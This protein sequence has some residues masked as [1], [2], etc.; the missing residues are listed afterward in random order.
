[1][2]TPLINEIDNSHAEIIKWDKNNIPPYCNS[3]IEVIFN[4]SISPMEYEQRLIGIIDIL[5]RS[6]EESIEEKQRTERINILKELNETV[7]DKLRN[8][9]TEYT[10]SLTHDSLRKDYSRNNIDSEPYYG[11]L[12]HELISSFISKQFK[13][14][15]ILHSFIQIQLEL[16][17]K[18]PKQPSILLDSKEQILI[19]D[20]L[21][22]VKVFDYHKIHPDQAGRAR[23]LSLIIGR[24]NENTSRHLEKISSTKHRGIYYNV[25]NLTKVRPFFERV[26]MYDIV[27]IIDEEIEK[28]KFN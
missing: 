28:V 4:G 10:G 14:F 18:I 5:K 21:K 17:N 8:F 1:M 9:R 7:E 3:E 22:R 26:S 20:L 19:I 11:D 23:L 24:S 2:L 12:G 27:Q 6:I 16:A 15:K 13:V 25:K